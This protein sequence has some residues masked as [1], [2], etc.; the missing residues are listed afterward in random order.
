MDMVTTLT[1]GNLIDFADF[2]ILQS[3]FGVTV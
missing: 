3:N 2:V 1:G